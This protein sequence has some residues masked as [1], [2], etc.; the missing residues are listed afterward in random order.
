MYTLL[1]AHAKNR[2]N[3]E[4]G[5][6]RNVL[7]RYNIIHIVCIHL[8]TRRWGFT[9]SFFSL[10]ATFRFF[11]NATAT[12]ISLSSSSYYIIMYVVAD[13]LMDLPAGSCIECRLRLSQYHIIIYVHTSCPRGV[14]N[15]E[16]RRR[17]SAKSLRFISDVVVG[18]MWNGR[19][20]GRR[21]CCVCI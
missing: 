21:R 4:H 14:A 8:C 10:S 7:W 18:G 6:V 12:L 13:N 20:N 19:R 11:V 2:I 3:G 5:R 16:Q 15:R 17:F 9:G 1:C